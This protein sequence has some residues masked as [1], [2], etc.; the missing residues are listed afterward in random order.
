MEVAVVVMQRRLRLPLLLVVW[1]KMSSTRWR[2]YYHLEVFRRSE[3]KLS[4]WWVVVS[5]RPRSSR[6]HTQ[7]K[8]RQMKSRYW[9]AHRDWRAHREDGKNVVQVTPAQM[10]FSCLC[11]CSSTNVFFMFV[12]LQ[13]ETSNGGRRQ[14]SRAAAF[15]SEMLLEPTV[16][17]VGHTLTWRQIVL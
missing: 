7:N 9:R 8:N 13:K 3:K 16:T 12:L 4:C 11:F 10:C 15:Y 1:L 6:L 2:C 14:C 17:P 5:T